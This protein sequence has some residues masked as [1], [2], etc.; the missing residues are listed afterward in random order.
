MHVK[1]RQGRIFLFYQYQMKN[2]SLEFMATFIS[3]TKY[4]IVHHI[5]QRNSSRIFH[6]ASDQIRQHRFQQ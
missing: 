4:V 6:S 5:A 1:A 3:E 2:M